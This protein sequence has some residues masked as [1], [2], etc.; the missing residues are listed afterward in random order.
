MYFIGCLRFFAGILLYGFY[1]GLKGFPKKKDSKIPI[2]L[3][4]I[5]ILCTMQAL[6]GIG[7]SMHGAL[8]GTKS[9]I[10]GSFDNTAGFASCIVAG[11]PFLLGIK[12]NKRVRT[13]V[14]SIAGIALLLSSSRSGIIAGCVILALLFFRTR[15]ALKWKI[16]MS[17]LLLFVFIASVTYFKTDSVKGRMLIWRCTLDLINSDI[18]LGQGWGAFA[19][20]YMDVQA[21]YFMRHP[22]SGYAF[23]ADNVTHPFNEILSVLVV[24][25]LFGFAVLLLYIFFLFYCYKKAP[26]DVGIASLLSL[27]GIFVCSLFSYPFTYPFTWFIVLLSSWILIHN[28]FHELLISSGMKLLM[29]ACILL[30]VSF[31]TLGLCDR[32]KAELSWKHTYEYVTNIDERLSA[33]K[34]LINRLGENP[35]F[36]YNY[37][38]ELYKA[39]HY[40]DCLLVAQR[41]RDYWADY[42]LELLL[43][44]TC[45]ELNQLQEAELHYQEAARMCPIRFLPMYRLA[46]LYRKWGKMEKSDSIAREILHKPI[47]VLSPEISAIKTEMQ[48]QLDGNLDNFC[49]ILE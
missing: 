39:K 21:N 30:I 32:I 49:D 11:V 38:I 17:L 10:T 1:I 16:A 48:L 4:T 46:L 20:H 43:G 34:S 41:C 2:L 28:A 23:F 47:K 27:V 31:G 13:V 36:L 14:V 25:G 6:Y 3:S 44:N 29:R 37:A 7:Q 8:M 40:N 42:D 35:F 26:S 5:V 12:T 33:Y 18:W 9:F 24:G 22:D 45:Q 15:T 19:A